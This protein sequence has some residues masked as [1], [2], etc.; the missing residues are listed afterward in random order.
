MKKFI[1]SQKFEILGGLLCIILGMLSGYSVSAGD[2]FWYTNINKPSFNPPGWIFGPVW[3]LLYFMMG[4]ALG[5]IWKSKDKILLSIFTLQM[6]FNLMWSP[7]FFF[8][9]RINW[10]LYDIICLWISLMILILFI[11]DKKEIFLLLLPY[12]LWVTFA[13]ILNWNLYIL[14]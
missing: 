5:K 10:A 13:L 1:I 3:S 9:Q 8:L 12:F 2:S 11:R 7:L 6:V 4:I 14:N